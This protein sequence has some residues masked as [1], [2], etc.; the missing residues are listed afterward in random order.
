MTRRGLALGTLVLLVTAAIAAAEEMSVTVK[1]SAVRER[2]SFTAKT[3][4]TLVYADRVV[5]VEVKG[6]WAH[7]SLVSK[8]IDGWMPKSALQTQQ[9]VLKAGAAAGTT[10]SSGEVA[11]AGKGFS[12]EVEAEYK[13]DPTLN[14]DAVDKMEAFRV[15]DDDVAAFLQ[16]GGLTVN[17][18]T[19]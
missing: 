12:E 17:G 10:A 16:R 2:A 13:K 6:D 14:Y 15:S 3:V 4:G 1:E 8:A 9:I 5:V 18:V 11:L 7:V 19:P